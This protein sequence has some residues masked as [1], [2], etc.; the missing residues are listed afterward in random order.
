MAIDPVGLSGLI[1]ALVALVIA[2]FQMMQALFATAD[3]YRNCRRAIMGDW[4]TLTRR[5]FVP[6]ELRFETIY[7]VPFISMSSY[8]GVPPKFVDGTTLSRQNTQCVKQEPR[9]WKIQNTTSELVTCKWSVLRHHVSS[10][11]RALRGWRR[12]E[13]S[14]QTA[15]A[16]ATTLG[17]SSDVF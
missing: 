12:F 11:D 7:T 4:A 1:I 9:W 6:W 3:G 17:L 2:L 5:K 8:D 13:S 14:H 15:E 10:F 16:T